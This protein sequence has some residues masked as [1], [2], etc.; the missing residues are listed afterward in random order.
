MKIYLLYDG[1]NVLST[2][3]HFKPAK[4]VSQCTMDIVTRI[5]HWFKVEQYGYRH[6]GSDLVYVFL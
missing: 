3:L 2:L 4:S 1:H 6:S 5:T